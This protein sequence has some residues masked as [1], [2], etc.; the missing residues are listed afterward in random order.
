MSK[1]LG[2]ALLASC[3]LFTASATRAEESIQELFRNDKADFRA[4]EKLSAQR[5]PKAYT[6]DPAS[7]RITRLA[8]AEEK[9]LSYLAPVVS[10]VG[11]SL[12]VIDQII[13]IASKVWNIIQQNAPVVNINTQYAAAVPQGITSW[14]QL[15][16]WKKPKSYI[17]GFRAK[18]LYGMSVVDVK[19][20]VIFTP[21]GKY[22]GKGRYLTGVT[23]V[24]TKVNV[25]WGYRFS[26]AAQVPDS[27][28]INEGS[29]EDPLASLQLKTAWRISTAIKSFDGASV[30]YIRGDG[31]FEEIA[32]PFSVKEVK[33]E[34]VESA[35]PLLLDPAGV[36]E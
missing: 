3:L 10:D 25:S 4:S 14:N 17:Y 15:S 2:K 8:A 22:Q 30:Y 16:E 11:G 26:L 19:Y 28:V 23:V 24:P 13:N 35:A 12:V 33:M 36:F 31:G 29:G 6:I 34:D 9:D 21:G 20:K 1:H 7:V 32:N 5:D 18:N 27:T